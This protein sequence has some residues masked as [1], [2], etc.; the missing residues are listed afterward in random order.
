MSK[1]AI[2]I[3]LIDKNRIEMLV[4]VHRR[5]FLQNIKLV[6]RFPKKA[7]SIKITRM[8]APTNISVVEWRNIV[9]LLVVFITIMKDGKL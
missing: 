9:G 1:P 8:I 6:S 2:R 5:G 7:P 4:G 3:S